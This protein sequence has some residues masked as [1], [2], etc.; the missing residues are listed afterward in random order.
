LTGA[1]ESSEGIRLCSR[2]V[3][4][5]EGKMKKLQIRIEKREIR[6]GVGIYIY[7]FDEALD[8]LFQGKLTFTKVEGSNT[9]M[10]PA[11]DIDRREIQRTNVLQVMMDD[12][13]NCGVRPTEGSGSAGSLKATQNHL[14]DM[15]KLVFKKNYEIKK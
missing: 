1:I 10:D 7:Q 8:E 12:L 3:F 14:E 11:V 2:R 15:R 13:W 4:K 5:E 9:A 6:R